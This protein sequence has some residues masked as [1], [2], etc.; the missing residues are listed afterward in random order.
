MND[1]LQVQ[2]EYSDE[3]LD[4]MKFDGEYVPLEEGAIQHWDLDLTKELAPDKL[5][6]QVSD[7]KSLIDDN[8]RLR[9]A[10]TE[11]SRGKLGPSL[12]NPALTEA[13]APATVHHAMV[14]KYGSNWFQ[15]DDLFEAFIR[16]NPS[17]MTYE[18]TWRRK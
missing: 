2:V 14:A 1:E 13:R 8:A 12:G 18:W 11:L 5:R 17:Y 9:A 3:Q 10:R 6:G 16:K 7:L 4:S 15:D